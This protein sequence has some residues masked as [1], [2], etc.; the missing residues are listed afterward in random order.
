MLKKPEPNLLNEY[1]EYYEQFNSSFLNNDEIY[2]HT[3]E[4][5]YQRKQQKQYEDPFRYK[6]YGRFIKGNAPPRPPAY[7][8]NDRFEGFCIDL[9]KQI[10]ENVGFEYTIELV[11]DGK[12]GVMNYE[13]GEWNGIVKE[14]MDK[15][16]VHLQHFECIDYK[17]IKYHGL[18]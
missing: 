6:P 7:N 1:Q 2:N 15:V 16:R 18:A 14:L 17:I 12:Y 5:E 13:T 8:P 10:A 4:K 3:I 9:L 11:P